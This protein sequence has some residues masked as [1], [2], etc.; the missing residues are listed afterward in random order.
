MQTVLQNGRMHQGW[1]HSMGQCS[2]TA[3]SRLANIRALIIF[4]CKEAKTHLKSEQQQKS[5]E[6]P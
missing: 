1:V 5:V 3:V 6:P 2:D 4:S